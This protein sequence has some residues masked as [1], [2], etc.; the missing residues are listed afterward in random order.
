MKSHFK[1]NKQERSGILFLLLLIILFQGIYFFVKS[2]PFSNKNTK[3]ILNE[4]E[5]AKI[6]SLKIVVSKD[7]GFKIYPFNPNFITDYKGYTLGMSPAEIDRLHTFRKTESYV[8]SAKQFQE[9]TKVSDSLLNVI[10]PYFKF[11]EWIDKSKPSVANK[12]NTFPNKIVPST[13]KV[14][15]D[16]NSLTAQELKTIYGIGD[17]LSARIIKFRDRL[18]GFI[19]NE[20]LYDVYGLE[21]EVAD[22]V[23]KR[24]QILNQP[25]I[26]KININTASTAEIAKLVYIPYK[27]ANRIVEQREFNG[28][29][30]SFDQLLEIDG[31][32][33][34]KLDRI[35]LYLSL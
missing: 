7:S 15:K 33:K 12:T 10:S 21:K 17:K 24:F 27:V 29:I 3:V 35:T 13:Q 26:T 9:A 30:N 23:L 22:R 11:P 1:F 6:D 32:P 19:I 25:I 18:G 4:A 16:L 31:F 14:I 5:Q 2:Q 34:E 28:R 8:N 20:Q